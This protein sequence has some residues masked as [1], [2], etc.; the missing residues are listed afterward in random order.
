MDNKTY[1]TVML[2][3]LVAFLFG[4]FGGMQVRQE[5]DLQPVRDECNTK[6]NYLYTELAKRA[7]CEPKFI[8]IE[9]GNFSEV[10]NLD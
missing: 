10:T 6:I 2:I 3:V 5:V 7:T 1:Y 8:F 9:V 4:L